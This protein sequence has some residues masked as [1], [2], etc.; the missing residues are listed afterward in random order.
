MKTVHIILNAHLDPIWLWPWSAGLDEVLATCRSACDRLDRHPD[1]FF[2]RGEAW[3]YEQIEKVDPRLFQR[4][5]KHVKAGRWEVAGGWWIQPD[6]NLPSGFGIKKQIELG[7]EYFIRR[8]GLFPKVGLNVDSFGHSA[9]LPNYMDA[10]GQRYY[11]MMRPMR[12]ELELPARIFRWRSSPTGKEIITFR[13]A[14]GY[15]SRKLS[16]SHIEGAISELPDG[17]EHTMCFVGVGDHGGGPTEAQIQ[18]VRDHQFS[19]PGWKLEFSTTSRFFKTIEFS[20]ARLPVV[21]GELQRH[22]V[23]CY[24]V[25]RSIKV[26]IRRTEHRLAQAELLLKAS[27]VDKKSLSEI[28]EA[29]KTVCF[30]HFHDTLGGTCVPSAYQFVHDDL[31]GACATAEKILHYGLRKKLA[32][33]P[34]DNRQQIVLFNCSEQTY[35]GIAEVEPWLDFLE[36]PEHGR[37]L[38]QDNRPIPFQKTHS[39]ALNI[40]MVK[41]LFQAKLRPHSLQRIKIDLSSEKSKS[42][43]RSQERGQGS[44]PSRN[45]SEISFIS[46]TPTLRNDRLPAIPVFLHSISDVSDTWSHGVK[47]YDENPS[48]LALWEKAKQIEDGPIRTTWQQVGRIGRSLLESE[49]RIYPENEFVDWH[50]R[51][52]WQERHRVLKAVFALK[53]IGLQRIDGIMGGHLKRPNDGVECPYRDWTLVNVG[54]NKFGVVSSDFFALDVNCERIRLTLLRSSLMAHHDPVP[55]TAPRKTY[56]DHAVHSFRLRIFY[57]PKVTPI[58][59]ERHALMTQ[60]PLLQAT[61]TRGMPAGW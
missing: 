46:R 19:I 23:G 37:L 16:L 43:D 9:S 41:L 59:L 55:T 60:R 38:D 33:I 27:R 31:G 25:H 39:E 52:N 51:V 21:T 2:T 15:N 4:I 13:I 36:W 42:F 47:S 48:N 22:A 10:A 30:H 32:K 49:W 29:W 3:V 35:E 18:F 58:L 11:V 40:G 12:Y 28:K 26:D 14:K 50:L 61:T 44:R 24:S 5:R 1:I 20:R 56:S 54:R 57:G 34:D 45:R 8:F 53:G 6:C 17:I 7:K